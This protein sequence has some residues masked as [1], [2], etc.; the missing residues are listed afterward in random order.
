MTPRTVWKNVTQEFRYSATNLHKLT[1]LD[2][3]IQYVFLHVNNI[4]FTL[5]PNT[6]W[7]FLGL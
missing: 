2:M 7:K 3:Y 5:P 1:F 4:L 6:E